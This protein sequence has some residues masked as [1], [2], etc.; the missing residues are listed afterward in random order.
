M[1]LYV[2]TTSKQ[3]TASKDPEPKNDQNGNQKSEK[4]IP[5]GVPEAEDWFSGQVGLFARRAV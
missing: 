4:N 1:K 2:D 3:V 5:G